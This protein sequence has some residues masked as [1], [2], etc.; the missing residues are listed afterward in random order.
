MSIIRI[1]LPQI[2]II[3]WRKRLAEVPG[4]HVQD[5]VNQ[6]LIN[7]LKPFAQPLRRFGQSKWRGRPLLDSGSQQDQPAELGTARGAL[8]RP[9][10]SADML[11][12]MAAS[13]LEDHGYGSFSSLE[14]PKAGLDASTLP[15]GSPSPASH[16]SDSDL[17]QESPK[18]TGKRKHKCGKQRGLITVVMRKIQE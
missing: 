5:S 10:A 4:Y 9:M 6:A 3:I 8:K 16:S 7:A 11:A 17:D 14:T 15:E 18:P 13:V 1:N 12:H 2:M